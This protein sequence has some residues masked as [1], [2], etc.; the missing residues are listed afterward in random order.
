MRPIKLPVWQLF[1]YN[2]PR[3]W[4]PRTSSPPEFFYGGGKS[5]VVV[6]SK[7]RKVKASGIV[8]AGGRST[9]MQ[10]NKAFTEVGGLK[11]IDNVLGKVSEVFDEVILVTNDPESYFCY[12]DESVR[13]VSDLIPGKGPL[14]GIHAG[15]YCARYDVTLAAACDMPFL[16]MDLAVHMIDML[17]DHDGVVPR[18]GEYFLPLFAVYTRRCL[19][20]IEESLLLDR[21]KLSDI[22]ESLDILY[23]NEKEIRRFGDPA[24]IFYNINNRED[25][26]HAEGLVKKV[27]V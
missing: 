15:L 24:V 26:K 14:S 21:L 18:I 22:Y 7:S 2:E 6:M 8:L 10:V 4:S 13:I 20:I 25:L 1:L 11:L 9:R 3:A 19:P 23:V 12:A 27:I 5:R 17:G 16:N